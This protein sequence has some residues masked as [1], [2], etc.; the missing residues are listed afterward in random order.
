MH[1]YDIVHGNIKSSN[2]LMENSIIKISDIPIYKITQNTLYLIRNSGSSPE[3]FLNELP[4]KSSDIWSAGYVLLELFIG[5]TPWRNKQNKGF[6]ELQIRNLIQKGK[7]FYLPKYIN[8]DFKNFLTSIFKLNPGHRPN[9]QKLLSHP[10]LKDIQLPNKFFQDNLRQF[11]TQKTPAS[12]N[13]DQSNVQRLGTNYIQ[14]TSATETY[15]VNTHINVNS[16]INAISHNS[17]NQ[18]TAISG[19][20]RYNSIAQQTSQ[21]YK[22][23]ENQSF[24][25][26]IPSLQENNHH[27]ENWV[28]NNNG[29]LNNKLL[30]FFNNQSGFNLNASMIQFL[31]NCQQEASKKTYKATD[32]QQ[33]KDIEQILE[34]DLGGINISSSS[35][36]IEIAN[37]NKNDGI[38]STR[39]IQNK[40]YS[41]PE[42]QYKSN[43]K[44]R[45]ITT[46]NF[47]KQNDN[48]I[49]IANNQ[50]S[51]ASMNSNGEYLL[52]PNNND[53]QYQSIQYAQETQIQRKGS[54]FKNNNL[55]GK[56]NN[57]NNVN[58]LY[59][60]NKNFQ[61]TYIGNHIDQNLDNNEEY[62]LKTD[63][64]FESHSAQN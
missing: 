28:D 19:Y 12:Y 44:Y 8:D 21:N 53:L 6:T 39:Q 34:Q 41:L 16:S 22:I 32:D 42:Q 30:S 23:N 54:Y 50:L 57:Q 62:D 17:V 10:F 13:T 35:S 29:G 5:G 20:N 51:Q 26:K 31:E 14:Q 36:E 49:A 25:C 1:K 63:Y 2:I 11:N 52:L 40:R 48:Q 61:Q 24:T 43:P 58:L 15:F 47:Q 9:A 56:Q 7:I 37:I 38:N 46:I 4:S 3:I 59:C 18:K 33:R 55:E 27:S 45:R 60:P 64:S